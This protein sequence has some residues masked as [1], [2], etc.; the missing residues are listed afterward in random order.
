MVFT[1]LEEVFQ[2]VGPSGGHCGELGLLDPCVCSLVGQSDGQSV[3]HSVCQSDGQSVGQSDGQAGGRHCVTAGHKATFPLYLYSRRGYWASS[4]D[5]SSSSC[6]IYISL[7]FVHLPLFSFSQT[8][9]FSRGLFCFCSEND[10]LPSFTSWPPE[11]GGRCVI[12]PPSLPL[13]SNFML[14]STLFRLI[15]FLPIV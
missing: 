12:T 13:I 4:S 6:H 5:G 3:G 9:L 7:F 10:F 1:V 8:V 15:L 2:S 11:A 14:S